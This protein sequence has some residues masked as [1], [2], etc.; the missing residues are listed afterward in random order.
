MTICLALEKEGVYTQTETQTIIM[1][2]TVV[3]L[4][5]YCIQLNKSEL[6]LFV[7]L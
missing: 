1:C 2:Q 3:D 4:N 6:L 5:N 7:N